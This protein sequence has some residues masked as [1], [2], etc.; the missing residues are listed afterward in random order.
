MS[1]PPEVPPSIDPATQMP[2][3]PA[4]DTEEV[5]YQGSPLLRGEI[6]RLVVCWGLGIVLFLAPF[7]WW[8]AKGYFPAWWI[9]GSCMVIALIV[10]LLP[11]LFTKTIRYRISNYRIDVEKGLLARNINTLELWHVEDISFHQSLADRILGVGT[12]TIR[13]ND[14]SDPYLPLHSLPKSRQL[15][16]VL[17]QRVIAVKRQRGV[18]K[19]DAGGHGVDQHA[20]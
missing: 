5:Y 1:I 8:Y 16:D 7:V 12:I 13:S 19:M 3:R 2:H 6:G 9:A 17:K 14:D 10:V 11:P 20:P 4:D 15:F 18:I